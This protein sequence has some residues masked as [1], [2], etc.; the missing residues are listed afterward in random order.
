MT[1]ILD[2]GAF[3]AVERY[4]RE[5]I[6]LI[7]GELIEGRSPVTHGG[8]IA[9]IWRGGTGRQARVA[10]LLKG[11]EIRPLDDALGRKAGMLLGRSG[12]RDAVDASLV[13]LACEGDDFLT[14]DIEDLTILAQATG[15]HIEIWPV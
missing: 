15:I 7:K 4:D 2:T 6:T 5:V 9:Q 1:L 12:G 8:I 10:Q 3:I 14:S 13:S 11:V